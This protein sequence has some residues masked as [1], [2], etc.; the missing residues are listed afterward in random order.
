MRFDFIYMIVS[1]RLSRSQQPELS[2]RRISRPEQLRRL[3]VSCMRC[4]S[5]HYFGLIEILQANVSQSL[6][7]RTNFETYSECNF[8]SVI[9]DIFSHFQ[10]WN[11]AEIESKS[12]FR[13]PEGLG[14]ADCSILAPTRIQPHIFF[15]KITFSAQSGKMLPCR[16]FDSDAN[17]AIISARI[18]IFESLQP[19]AVSCT[20]RTPGRRCRRHPARAWCATGGFPWVLMSNGGGGLR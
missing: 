7:S 14:G 1:R 2:G 8:F 16:F 15:L 17:F 9:F 10:T 5:I 4:E 19:A 12:R 18:Q 6:L 3:Q 20:R 13:C 11:R